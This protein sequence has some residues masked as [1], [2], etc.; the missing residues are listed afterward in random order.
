MKLNL[1][2]NYKK[3]NPSGQETLNTFHFRYGNKTK[4]F[5]KIKNTVFVK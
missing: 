3:M 1:S 4:K 5:E 2:L